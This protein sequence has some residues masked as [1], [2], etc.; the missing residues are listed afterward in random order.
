VEAIEM[1]LLFEELPG[2]AMVS[3][4][5]CGMEIQGEEGGGG[6]NVLCPDCVARP[7]YPV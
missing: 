2:E 5:W 7:V 1:N 6:G 3:C 4:S